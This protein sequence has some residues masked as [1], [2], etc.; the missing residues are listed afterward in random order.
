MR[1][2]KFTTKLQAALQESQSLALGRDHQIIEPVHLMQ[3]LLDQQGGTVRPLLDKCGA[4]IN[5]LRSQLREALDRL[6]KVEGTGGE[7][8]LSNDL[9]RLLNLTDKIAQKRGDQYIT[10][11]LFILAALEDKGPLAKILKD[12]GVQK[13]GVERAID[14]IRGGNRSTTRTSRSSG[15]RSRNTPSTSPSA[16]SRASSIRSSAATTRSAARSRCCSVA[17]RTTPC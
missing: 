11:E 1:Q 7:V 8:H 10:S 17:P 16:R 9:A 12:A 2:D 3:A 15:A 6:P 4:N 14:E 5:T 13:G